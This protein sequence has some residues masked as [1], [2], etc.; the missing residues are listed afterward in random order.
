M[1]DGV[2]EPVQEP[3]SSQGREPKTTGYSKEYV[4]EIRKEAGDYRIRAKQEAEKVEN[5]QKALDARNAE[6]ETVKQE[7]EKAANERVL[8]AELKAIAIKE[9]MVD[10]DGLKLL[11]LSTVKIGE[12]GEIE[13][14]EALFKTAKESKPY[15]FKTTT[16]TTS[17]EPKPKEG[18]S[19]PKN[20][21]EMTAEEYKAARSALASTTRR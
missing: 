14:A 18:D 2:N 12:N 5:L 8:R 21:M 6:I 7:T 13:G 11:D 19:K 17:T 20:A 9:G 16:T 1:T 4:E 10:L 15:L 3:V